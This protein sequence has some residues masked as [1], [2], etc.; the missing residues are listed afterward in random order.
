MIKKTNLLL[1]ISLLTLTGCWDRKEINDI[2]VVMAIGIDKSPKGYIV[3]AQIPI[4]EAAGKIGGNDTGTGGKQSFFIESSMGRS[5]KEAFENMQNRTARRFLFSHQRILIIGEELAKSGVSKVL[6]FINR[7]GE[8]RLS[9]YILVAKGKSLDILKTSAPLDHMS[10]EAIRQITKMGMRRTTSEFLNEIYQ[11]G[12]DPIIPLVEV[13]KIQN[14][15]KPEIKKMAVFKE[16]KMRFVSNQK[17]T[18]GIYWLT[19]RIKRKSITF[20]VQENEEITVEILDQKK[21]INA[22]IRTDMPEFNVNIEVRGVIRENKSSLDIENLEVFH[23]VEARLGEEI[24]SQ[25]TA[26]LEE[27]TSR[28]IDSFGF[29]NYLYR[30][31]NIKWETLWKD[32]WEKILPEIKANIHVNVVIQ[33]T[34]VNTIGLGKKK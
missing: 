1:T 3:S 22:M 26:I 17:Q 32:K 14:I 34:G 24:K 23:Q 6:D 4:P 33:S 8:S 5:I 18:L 27:T 12:K 20:P 2:A 21:K 28:Q 30:K 16:D 19:N 25:V 13:I 10:Y 9:A 29:G 7:N 15:A 11:V 31:E